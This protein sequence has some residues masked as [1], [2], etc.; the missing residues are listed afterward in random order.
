QEYKE[1]D[2]Q[3]YMLLWATGTRPGTGARSMVFLRPVSG[4][5]NTV[6][7]AEPGCDP[8]TG[9]SILTF[10]ATLPPPHEILETDTTVN[11]RAVTVDGLGNPIFAN[12]V[13]RILLAYYEGMTP[14]DLES[15]IFDIEMIATDIWEIQDYGGG[16]SADLRNAR[17]RE[18]NG[19]Q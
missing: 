19:E 4:E 12:S 16:R 7:D 14:Q 1:S 18:A 11:W 3:V 8:D 5:V 13:D 17:H 15:E 9:E 6:V 10:D 2:T